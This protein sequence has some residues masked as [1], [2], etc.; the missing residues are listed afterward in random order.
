MIKMKET[1]WAVVGIAADV[2]K[3]L[4]LIGGLVNR[5]FIQAFLRGQL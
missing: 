5:K 3:L 4:R 1:F 2:N